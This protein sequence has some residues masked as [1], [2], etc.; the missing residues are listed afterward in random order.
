[1]AAVAVVVTVVA[2]WAA[3]TTMGHRHQPSAKNLSFM[4]SSS[5]ADADDALLETVSVALSGGVYPYS[6]IPGGVHSAA[7]FSAK[8]ESDPVVAEHYSDVSAATL[9]AEQVS[10]PRWAYMSYRID[11]DVYWTK[12][13]LP[14]REGETILTDGETTIRGRCGNRVSETPKL[15]VSDEEPAAAAFDRRVDGP[16]ATTVA[17]VSDSKTDDIAANMIPGALGALPGSAASGGS[18]PQLQARNDTPAMGSGFGGS[19]GGIGGG[20]LPFGASQPNDG[21]GRSS[22]RGSSSTSPGGGGGSTTPGGGSDS[23]PPGGGGGSTPPGGGGGSTTPGGGGGSTPPG[24]GGGSTTPGGGG[25]STT[26]GGG[27]GS[28]TP[29]GGGGST[30]PGGGGGSTTPGGGGGSTTSGGGGGSDT[31][32]GGSGGP[33][34]GNP[35]IPGDLPGDNMPPVPGGGG[36]EG[37]GDNPRSVPEP[38]S[39][40]LLAGGTAGYALSRIRARRR[41]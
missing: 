34:S 8:R 23:T 14:L 36:T 28:T 37:P 16:A 29:G 21:T 11:D 32:G 4:A 20:S 1:M 5:V 40:L 7:E 17:G 35:P 3:R 27:G 24:G 22:T 10:E 19:G 9:H 12:N 41:N 26:P 18:S 6:V 39:M 33:G 31:P 25:G 15:P 38:A 2:V 13:K 30:T